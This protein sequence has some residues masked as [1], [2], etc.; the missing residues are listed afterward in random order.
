MENKQKSSD[1]ALSEPLQQCSV[2]GCSS[3][4]LMFGCANEKCNN[5]NSKNIKKWGNN[6]KEQKR[7]GK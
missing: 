4:L 2:S 3:P 7:S 6:L 5:S 1:E